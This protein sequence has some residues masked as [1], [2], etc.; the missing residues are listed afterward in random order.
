MIVF[1]LK[2]RILIIDVICIGEYVFVFSVD[3]LVEWY[4]EVV[5]IVMQLE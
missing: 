2:D 4:L 5:G 3:D 1:V